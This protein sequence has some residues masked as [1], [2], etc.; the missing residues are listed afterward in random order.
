MGRPRRLSSSFL[1]QE[2]KKLN[3]YRADIR[4]VQ[5]GKPPSYSMKDGPFVYQVPQALTVGQLVSGG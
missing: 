3:R 5:Q 1:M 2:R 4:L